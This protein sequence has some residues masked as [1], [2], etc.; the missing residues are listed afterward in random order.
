MKLKKQHYIGIAIGILIL[1]GDIAL[2]YGQRVFEFI[3]GIAVI[4][5]V[6]PFITA[7]LT[8]VGREKGKEEM[9]LEFARNLV[10]SVKAGTPISK[11]IINVGKKDYGSL[12]PHI[13]KL[14]NQ[15]AVGIPVSQALATFANDV[16]N[17]V[18]SRSVYLII[19]AEKSG[20]HIDLILESTAKSV[21]EVEDLQKERQSSMYNLVI[22][23]YIIFFIFLIIMIAVQVKF[24]PTMLQT[25]AEAGP[26]TGVGGLN[27]GAGGGGAGV[28]TELLGRLFLWLILVQGFFCGL[29]IG[30]LSEGS[31]KAGVKHSAIIVV[32]AYLITTGVQAFLA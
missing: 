7:F 15:I 11:S 4:V 5:G 8:E 9:F 13:A 28:S 6:L 29:V 21:S 31:V 22:E 3:L 25:V 1:I 18:V 10:E 14:S 16:K 19:Q 27:F 32:M 2:F 12:S 30:K 17:R 24:I 26:S 23:G 20:G